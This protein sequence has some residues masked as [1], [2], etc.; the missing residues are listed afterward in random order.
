MESIDDF[1]LSIEQAAFLF[2][3][4]VTTISRMEEAE[5][6]TLRPSAALPRSV[7]TCGEALMLIPA[8]LV[9]VA[10]LYPGLMEE[11]TLIAALRMN[12]RPGATVN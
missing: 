6:D 7:L 10:K 12:L 5:L 3:R 8:G 4:Y 11:E 9:L 1:E 2:A